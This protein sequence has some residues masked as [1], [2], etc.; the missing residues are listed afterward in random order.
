[1]RAEVYYLVLLASVFTAAVS[2]IFLKKSASVPHASFIKEYL[3]ANVIIGYALL[4]ASTLMTIFAFT[5]MD[6]KNGPIIESLGS[7]FVLVL[8]ALFLHEK[9]TKK[10]VIGNV[11]ILAG[12]A[13]FYLF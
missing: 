8:S 4:L 7:I 5:G 11:L 3:N 6:Y 13:V 1:M 2:Q 10:K 12:I 9:I